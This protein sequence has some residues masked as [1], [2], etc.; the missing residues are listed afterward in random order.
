MEERREHCRYPVALPAKV[1]IFGTQEACE[2]IVTDIS[3]SGVRFVY[4]EKINE[5]QA[6]ELVVSIDGQDVKMKAVVVWSARLEGQIKVQ[7]GVKIT[8]VDF[9]GDRLRLELFFKKFQ[10]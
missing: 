5:G 6:L 3:F 8:G 10:G 1:I 7:H 9:D 2:G 4:D